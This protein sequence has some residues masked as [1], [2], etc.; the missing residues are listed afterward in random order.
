[1][2]MICPM[3][4]VWLL[5]AGSVLLA[6]TYSGV[7]CAQGTPPAAA[8]GEWHCPNGT[9]SPTAAGCYA[10][11]G[12]GV[13]AYNPQ[14]QI[15]MQGAAAAAGVVGQ[16]LS[17]KVN[18]FLFG[19]PQAEAE[20]EARQ[21]AQAEAE[22]RQ[23]AE[24]EAAAR[25][26]AEAE[27]RERAA[28]AAAAAAAEKQ[29]TD[30]IRA[31]LLAHMSHVVTFDTAAAPASEA[32]PG[33]TLVNGVPVLKFDSASGQS[34]NFGK[35]GVGVS[36]AC[37]TAIN[38]APGADQSAA[39]GAA[40]MP[41]A[42]AR[43]MPA[44]PPGATQ[45]NGIPL[46]SFS[47]TPRLLRSSGNPNGHPVGIRQAP[48]QCR[49]LTAKLISI[50]ALQ[51]RAELAED[52]YDRYGT[53]GP[54]HPLNGT[55]NV[56]LP[57]K[58][59]RISDNA[60][61]MKALL[62]K[63]AQMIEQLLAPPDSGYRASIYQD[64][65]DHN[66]IYLVFRGTTR[67][68]K[69]MQA[70]VK[71]ETGQQSDYFRKAIALARLVKKSVGGRVP[72]EIIGHSLGGGMADVA[73][74]ITHTQTLSFNPEGVHPNTLS[75]QGFDLALARK[76]AS[77][78]VTDVVV[79]G[80]ILN[81]AQDHRGGVKAYLLTTQ[82]VGAAVAATLASLGGR[83]AVAGAFEA[84][85]LSPAI[86][87]RV[88]LEPDPKDVGTNPLINAIMLHKMSSVMDA[89]SYRFNRVYDQY[90]RIGCREREVSYANR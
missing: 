59:K 31:S 83:K 57:P 80:E 18:N 20:A 56:P 84:D 33:T 61:A 74:A 87:N 70:D 69:D 25:Q 12:A 82:P 66:K 39:A 73:G 21:R 36:E 23:R 10:A 3:R 34:A 71:Q 45:V 42:P 60:E 49:A 27:A 78:Y 32:P 52:V 19:N 67:N 2:A 9:L 43:Q 55:P 85:S 15:M 13:G 6:L 51:R 86:G 37:R 22:A 64:A 50:D 24:A 63:N 1:M 76:L 11:S 8:A 53:P 88:T 41:G 7:V 30:A 38:C 16:Y 54:H 4:R 28:V 40:P 17:N 26:Q 65:A 46:L 58:M 81:Y 44:T 48:A 47:G 79:H 35:A 62:G 90:D 89:I 75:G 77:K 14:Q 5:A 68:L 72:M 29:H